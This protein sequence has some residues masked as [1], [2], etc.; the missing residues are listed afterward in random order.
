MEFNEVLVAGRITK[1][2]DL[3]YTTTGT[4][5]LTMPIAIN[6]TT[7]SGENKKEEVAFINVVVWG[8][9]AENVNTYLQKGSPV[10]VKGKLV[11]RSWDR[12]DGSKGYATEIKADNVQFL[13]K[14]EFSGTTPPQEERPT[15][16]TATATPEAVASEEEIIIPDGSVEEMF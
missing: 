1:D 13:N 14:P 12:P 15:Y 16:E 10:F 11:T 3:K 9:R 8:K 6:T 4:M 7:G 2:L 5:V